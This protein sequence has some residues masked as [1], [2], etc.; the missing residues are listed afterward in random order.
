[1]GGILADHQDA[2][3]AVEATA[4]ENR[5]PFG[6]ELGCGVDGLAGGGGAKRSERLFCVAGIEF[7][8][9]PRLALSRCRTRSCREVY[10]RPVVADKTKS[11]RRRRAAPPPQLEELVR[12]TT[13]PSDPES[14]LDFVQRRMRELAKDEKKRP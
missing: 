4:V 2:S 12:D 5:T 3:C 6:S 11:K 7:S 14:P 1:V 10:I 9:S 8:H 13:E